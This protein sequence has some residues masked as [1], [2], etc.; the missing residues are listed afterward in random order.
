MFRFKT[1]RQKQNQADEYKKFWIIL[2][3]NLISD[4]K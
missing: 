3:K 4:W 1:D 2:I